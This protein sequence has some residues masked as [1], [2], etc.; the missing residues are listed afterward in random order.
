MKTL[1]HSLSQKEMRKNGF[2]FECETAANVNP[3]HELT[4]QSF[5]VSII[6]DRDGMIAVLS[7]CQIHGEPRTN[8]CHAGQQHWR[9][10]EQRERERESER[11]RT[12]IL[13]LNLGSSEAT[14]K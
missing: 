4:A 10:R 14:H 11:S 1:I 7:G 5:S 3:R 12:Q 6:A 8:S 2:E 13:P 9:E